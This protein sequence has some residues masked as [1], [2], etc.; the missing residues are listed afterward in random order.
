MVVPVDRFSELI[1]ALLDGR[2]D[3]IAA[4]LAMTEANRERIAFS[5][6]LDHRR[7]LVVKRRDDELAAPADLAGRRITIGAGSR[8]SARARSLRQRHSEL[9]IDERRDLSTPRQLDLLGRGDIDLT[10]AASNTLEAALQFRDRVD[11][12]FAVSSETGVG[13]GIRPD[14]DE[15]KTILDRFIRQQKLAEDQRDHR[16]GDLDAIKQAGTLRVATRNSTANYFVWRG[17]LLGFE[18]ELAERFAH[19]LGLRLEV[20]VADDRRELL[21]MVR[22]GRADFAAAFLTP[23]EQGAEDG[24]RYSRPYHHAVKQVVTDTRDAALDEVGHLAGRTFHVRRGSDAWDELGRLLDETPVDFARAPIGDDAS[25]EAIIRRVAKGQYDL[26]LVDDHIA[27]N[28]AVWHDRIRTGLAVGEPEPNRWAFRADNERLLTAANRFLHDTYQS[29]FYNVVYTKYFEDHDRIKRY[30]SQRV[31]LSSAQQL[32]P[33]DPLIK[34]YA[35]RHGFDWRLIAALT[36]Q[37]S[38]F[39][40]DKRSWVG[41]EGLMQVM[42]ATAEQVDIEGDLSDPETNIRAGTRYLAWLRK[43]F[44][45]DLRVRD[46]MWFTL[47]AYNAGIGHVRDARRLAEGLGLDPDQW[48]DNAERAMLKLSERRHFRDARFGY[49]RGEEPVD[50]VRSIRERYE[51]YMLWTNDCWPNCQPR[52]EPQVV[53]NTRSRDPS[54]SFSGPQMQFNAEEN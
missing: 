31:S 46:R 28:A 26:T 44:D 23:P 53:E 7:Q 10:L 52:P 14:A 48:F 1:P 8:Y 42:P 36:F 49:V 18:Y 27:K 19:S 29:K 15:L 6:A 12:A 21:A 5:V 38:S 11:S 32:T 51:A 22:D 47:A 37:E 30:Q 43:R 4:N 50:Y 40:P 33:Y 41:A 39:N 20:V 54:P 13:W 25:T 17:Q 45:D 34:R 24:I 3:L 9:T 2:G 35:Q 16:A